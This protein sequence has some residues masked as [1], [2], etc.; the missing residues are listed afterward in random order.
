M[1]GYLFGW[2]SWLNFVG[3]HVYC[4]GCGYEGGSRCSGREYRS[5]LDSAGVVINIEFAFQPT[6]ISM[7]ILYASILSTTDAHLRPSVKSHGNVLSRNVVLAFS[8]PLSK[9]QQT[10]N[11]SQNSFQTAAI[12]FSGN[13]VG[14]IRSR[15]YLQVSI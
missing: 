9:P 13:L 8:S 1:R 2:A 11:S 3:A 4:R 12:R 14:L 5:H 6:H 15:D 7:P 10:E